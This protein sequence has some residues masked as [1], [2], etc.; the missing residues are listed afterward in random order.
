MQYIEELWKPWLDSPGS[1][2]VVY[3]V[4]LQTY[5]RVLIQYIEVRFT[6]YQS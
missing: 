3:F 4:R 6:D 5:G 2:D 1:H